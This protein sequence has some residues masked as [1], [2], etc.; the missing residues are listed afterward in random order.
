MTGTPATT[1]HSNSRPAEIGGD[2]A[3]FR[4]V[5]G[6][7][8]P[9]PLQQALEQL[10]SAQR[11]LN[12]AD[13][14]ILNWKRQNVRVINGRELMCWDLKAAT[15]DRLNREL[16]ALNVKRYACWVLFTKALRYHSLAKFGKEL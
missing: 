2:H 1:S 12:A 15:R 3:A 8:A 10:H 11:A 16:S 9:D 4:P 5:E 14:A 6:S 7:S 13:Q